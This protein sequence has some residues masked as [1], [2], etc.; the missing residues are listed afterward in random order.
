MPKWK[1]DA[2]EFVVSVTYHETRGIQTYL[3]RPIVEHLGKPESIKFVIVGKK[4]EVRP[5]K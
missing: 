3:P 2:K 4:V 1:K 5:H